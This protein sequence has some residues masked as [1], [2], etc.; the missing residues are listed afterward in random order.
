MDLML[1]SILLNSKVS[2]F[3]IQIF[4]RMPYAEDTMEIL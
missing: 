4:S 2:T 1:H 3:S